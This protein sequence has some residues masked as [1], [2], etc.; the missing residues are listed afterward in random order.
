MR[1]ELPEGPLYAVALT[2]A[3]A[4]FARR[5]AEA[6][7]GT[8]AFAPERFAGGGVQPLSEPTSALLARL[9]PGAG[10]FL[11]VMAAGIAVRAV[12]PLLRDK[13]VDPAVV[14]LDPEGRFAVPL[15]SGH[16]GGANAL[17]REVGRRLGA[18]PVLTTA[19][20]AAGAPAAE[21]WA[22]DRGLRIEDRAGVIRV[23]AAWAN[24]DPVAAYLDPALGD[25]ALLDE[26]E[27]F[28]SFVTGDEAEARE[29]E[30]KGV[31]LAVTH[32]LLPGLG[33]ALTLRPPCLTLGA[34]C[35]EGADPGEVV[36]GA[37]RALEDAGFAAGAVRQ[38]ASVDAKA[39][40]PA[41]RELARALGVP[42]VTLPPEAL[43]AVPVPNPSARVARAVGTPS[44]AEAAALAASRGGRLVLPKVKGSTWTLAAALGPWERA[45]D[46]EG[47]GAFR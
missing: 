26:L 19:T 32:R 8:A 15:L 35:R 22:R 14:V 43:A 12:A 40:E 23:N 31:L 20:D 42:Y 28:L 34:G 11:L 30:A 29:E 46:G 38:V 41:L 7:P 2:R 27:P 9:W 24:G 36:D 45:G 33:A 25:P 37:R 6:F 1:E 44:V 5:L 47:A 17:A 21:V 4:G 3:G 13:A 10:G 39:Q 16:L 18:V